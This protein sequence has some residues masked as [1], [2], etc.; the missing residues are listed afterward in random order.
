M[1]TPTSFAGSSPV[2]I[3]KDVRKSGELVD[4]LFLLGSDVIVASSRKT[5][6]DKVTVAVMQLWQN[7]RHQTPTERL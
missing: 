1:H 4:W 5:P 6:D 2:K 3:Q 7:Y